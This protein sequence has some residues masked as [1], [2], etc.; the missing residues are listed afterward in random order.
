MA[1]TFATAILS[2]CSMDYEL[3]EEAS[4]RNKTTCAI[5]ISAPDLFAPA[6]KREI[7]KT[8]AS[9]VGESL[10]QK[11]FT[12]VDANAKPQFVM[13]SVWIINSEVAETTISAGSETGVV[14]TTPAKSA[15]YTLEMQALLAD[16]PEGSDWSWRSIS[17][18]SI[19][20]NEAVPENVKAQVNW[21]FKNFPPEEPEAAK[22]IF[23]QLPAQK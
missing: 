7:E 1:L 9:A 13:R 4:F 22:P 6:A 18:M 14:G 20:A 12:V 5:E 23:K 3:K 15:A 11:G 10:R 19:S 8:L 2:A 17:P 21:C 16:A